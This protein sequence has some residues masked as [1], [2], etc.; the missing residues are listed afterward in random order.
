MLSSHNGERGIVSKMVRLT[1]LVSYLLTF[2]EYARVC[3]VYAV[4]TCDF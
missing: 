1:I 3:A 2:V 4:L